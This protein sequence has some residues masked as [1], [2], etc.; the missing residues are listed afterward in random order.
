MRSDMNFRNLI[1]QNKS[2]VAVSLKNL[3][4]EV[5]SATG[6]E[7]LGY[8]VYV[9]RSGHK[10]SPLKKRSSETIDWYVEN[11]DSLQLNFTIPSLTPILRGAARRYK[12]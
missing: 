6:V 7:C 1:Y 8:V 4:K 10:I 9:L 5:L 12:E 2:S 3:E 11:I